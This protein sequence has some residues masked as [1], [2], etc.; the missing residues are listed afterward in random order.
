MTKRAAPANT[1]KA[2]PADADTRRI[3]D[4]VGEL[5]IDG[6]LVTKVKKESD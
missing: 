5:I 3:L 4:E 6:R 2:P 1:P